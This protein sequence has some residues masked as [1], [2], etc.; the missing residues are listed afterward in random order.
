MS[1][2]L[3]VVVAGGGR[4]G[5]RTTRIL[6]ARGHNVLVI[7]RDADACETLSDEYVA[8]IVE[9]DA[10]RPDILE[11][12]ALEKRDVL[13]AL[14]GNG[15]MNL[16]ICMVAS[17]IEPSLR[18]V[19]RIESESERGY[20]QFVDAVVFPEQAGAR[21]AANEVVGGAVQTIADVV[22]APAA[23]KRLADIAL[24]AGS[25]VVSGDDGNRIARPDT[26]LDPGKRYVVAVEPA[27]TEEVMNLFRG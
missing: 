18:T 23:N 19:A 17:E 1:D 15:A 13:A 5:A 25:L 2:S 21:V 8:T 10:V 7:E 3:D 16:A 27:V 4:V 11:Q 6:D 22:G 26:T 9:G 24:P 12:A 14:T 20:G